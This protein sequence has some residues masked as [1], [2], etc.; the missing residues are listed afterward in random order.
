[1]SKNNLQS[2]DITVNNYIS[3][4]LR[5]TSDTSVIAYL[6]YIC[7]KWTCLFRDDSKNSN[8]WSL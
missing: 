6:E 1:L 8:A 5:R 2:L 7:F 4:Q 3:T